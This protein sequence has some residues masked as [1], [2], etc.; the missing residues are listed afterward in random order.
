MSW[1]MHDPE[2]WDEV[3]RKAIVVHMK[4][5]GILSPTSD[6]DNIEGELSEL[7]GNEIWSALVEWAG[8]SISGCEA[9]YLTGRPR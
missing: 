7:N 4:R 5:K 3:C 1:A 6:E 9:D 8:D 2:G